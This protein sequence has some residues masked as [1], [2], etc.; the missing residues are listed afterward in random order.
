MVTMMAY[1][2]ICI[3]Y[4]SG[5]RSGGGEG[6]SSGSMVMGTAHRTKPLAIST[7]YFVMSFTHFSSVSLFQE[8]K[9]RN[10]R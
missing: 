8:I 6:S 2:G 9:Y 1:G 5:K 3:A 10:L 7:S 4:I